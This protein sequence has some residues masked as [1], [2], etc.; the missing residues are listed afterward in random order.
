MLEKAP[1][2]Q[3]REEPR[4]AAV[5]GQHQEQLNNTVGMNNTRTNNCTNVLSIVDYAAQNTVSYATSI[6][7]S[8]IN[9]PNYDS[10]H[11]A[12][13]CGILAL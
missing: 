6:K 9:L 11:G 12:R 10:V 7:A 1:F 3:P 5:Q 8:N 4:P 2:L 13:K